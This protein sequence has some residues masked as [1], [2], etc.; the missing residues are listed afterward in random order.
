MGGTSQ[1]KTTTTT[2]NTQ[3][4]APA[5]PLLGG[6][7]GR[8]GQVNPQLTGGEEAA[9]S[10][11]SANSGLLG[12]FAPAATG[13]AG[14]LLAG[15]GATDQAPM[16]GA[17]YQQYRRQLDPY[18]SG[19]NLDPYAT[20]GFGNAL[21]TLNSDI[22]NQINAQFAAAG[23]DLS[24]MNTQTLARGLAQGEGALIADQYNRNV[25]N[26]LAAAD[27][28]YG[29]GNTTGGLL[30]GLN[31]QAIANKQAGF[32]AAETAQAFASDPY[33][34]ALAIE[35]QRRGIPL[36][37][38]QQIAAVGVPIAGLGSSSQG[39]QTQTISTPFNPLSLAP[40][41]F[42]PFSGGT[43]LAGMAWNGASGLFGNGFG[44]A[45]QFNPTDLAIN[46][47]LFPNYGRG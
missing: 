38:L 15:G 33:N 24:G 32:G 42:A 43:S 5:Q 25:A 13:F 14:N 10:G 12:Q 37:T 36:S 39:T 35:A 45:G 4:W 29:A 17:A 30:S 28:L 3:P 8:L 9:L 6:I 7:L 1:E 11:L 18:A 19:A 26:Q 34:R 44:N 41:A 20:P 40:L 21:G 27:S 2:Q 46:Q 22:T 47:R 31:Q 23:R 16:I